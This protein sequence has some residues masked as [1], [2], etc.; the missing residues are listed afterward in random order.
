MVRPLLKRFRRAGIVAIFTVGS[1][2]AGFLM[3]GVALAQG[4]CSDLGTTFGQ[5]NYSLASVQ[6]GTHSLWMRIKSTDGTPSLKFNLSGGG[7]LCNQTMTT[8]AATS[9]K[10]VKSTSA[11][12]TTGGTVAVQLAGSEA[13]VGVDCLVLTSD[14][15]FAPTTAADC[16]G[17]Q[18]DTT[19]PTA[20]FTAPANNATISG[21]TTVSAN[22]ADAES[23]IA[24]VLFRVNGRNDLDFTDATAPYQNSL[25]TASIT[26][27]AIQLIIIATNGDG[28]QTTV[29]RNVTVNNTVTPPPDTTKPTAAISSPTN[30]A[31]VSGASL[32][33][34]AT[35][36]D[37]VAVANVRLYLDGALYLTDTTSPYAFTV[38]TTSMTAGTHQLYAIVTDTS[39][40]T[41]QSTTIS[42]TYQSQKPGDVDGDGDVDLQDFFTLR[43]NYGQSG[44][45]RAQ[46][47]LSGNGTVDLEDFF[48][49]RQNYGS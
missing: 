15:G 21:T 26:N 22:A 6:A 8:T 5:A 7:T 24:N 20:S 44:R 42:F 46:G 38:N 32:S 18:V 16:T 27:G 30:G 10:W 34:T 13:G 49:L 3:P 41:Q 33:V 14:T 39:N 19:S 48:I 40:N 37:N 28:L 29:T 43:S 11:L 4:T 45:T 9:W 23:G 35:A 17:P 36:T 25:N 31:T 47:D 1:T 12:T 2:V